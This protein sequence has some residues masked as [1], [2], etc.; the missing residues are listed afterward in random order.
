MD[1]PYPYLSYY[2]V[3][4]LCMSKK[5]RGVVG[6]FSFCDLLQPAAEYELRRVL[7]NRMRRRDSVNVRFAPKATEC[8][9]AAKRRYVP[10]TDIL[11]CHDAVL[12]FPK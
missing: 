3:Q 7:I 5:T 11:R 6:V 4:K 9:V 12:L 10:E 2:P 8:C 1:R